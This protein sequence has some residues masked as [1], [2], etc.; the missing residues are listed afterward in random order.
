M[1]HHKNN[2]TTVIIRAVQP[3][4]DLAQLTNLIHAAYAPHA[5][6]GLRYWGTHQSIDDTAKRLSTG[7]GFIAELNGEYVGTITV[8]PPQ[9]ESP[10]KLYRQPHTWSI[11]QFA[12]SPEFKGKG[13]GKA[14][15]EAALAHARSNGARAIGLDTAAP[16]TSLIAMYQ[17]WGYE[18]A[19]EHKWPQTNYLSV[20]MHRVVSET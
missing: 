12:V 3:D 10:I 16:A 18:I 6:K 17:A 8:R 2:T 5:A 7:Q 4:D 19:G 14:L 15:H 11:S 20:L 1:F 13:L 9:P